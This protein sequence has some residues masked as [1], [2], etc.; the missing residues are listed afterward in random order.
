M[1]LD[2][3]EEQ[4]DDG[5]EKEAEDDEGPAKKKPR[6]STSNQNQVAVWS[7][8]PSSRSNHAAVSAA[9]DASNFSV[10]WNSNENLNNDGDKS[11]SKKTSGI[12]SRQ[13]EL[14]RITIELHQVGTRLGR[15]D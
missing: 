6:Q 9:S 11:T 2:A 10:V 3:L 13:V 8:K 1:D 4:E 5:V 12:H 15:H 14:S 7:F